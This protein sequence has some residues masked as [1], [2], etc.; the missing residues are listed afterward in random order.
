MEMGKGLVKEVQSG[1]TLIIIKTGAA[2]GVAAEEFVLSL[3]SLEAPRLSRRNGDAPF[4]QLAKE[5][6]RS[7]CAGQIVTYKIE[8]SVPSRSFGTI[9]VGG[10]D[11]SISVVS[12]GFASVVQSNSSS[13]SESID[14]FLIQQERAKNAGRGKWTKDK[15]RIAAG[16]VKVR[17]AGDGSVTSQELEDI[18]KQIE[19]KPVSAI[20]EYIRD[21]SMMR[22]QLVDFNIVVPFGLA[23]VTC[24]SFRGKGVKL[25]DGSYDDSLAKPEPFAALAKQYTERRL[26]SRLVNIR[27]CGGPRK[28]NTF[29]GKVEHPQGDISVALLKN[30]LARVSDWTLRY[31]PNRI[32]LRAAEGYAK[33]NLLRIWKNYTPPETGN[34]PTIQGTVI[35]VPSGDTLV[36]ENTDSGEEH[37]VTIS[38]IRVPYSGSRDGSKAAEPFSFEAHDTLRSLAI[39]KRVTATVDYERRSRDKDGNERMDTTARQFAT[40]LVGK[41]NLAQELVRKGYAKVARHRA[42]EPRSAAYDDLMESELL[43]EKAQ[44]GIHGN[45]QKAKSQPNDVTRDAQKAKHFMAFLTRPG[46]NVHNG[47]VNYCFNASRFKVHIPKENV[48]V[49]VSLIGVATPRTA[50]AARNGQPAQP[51]EAC[52]G[53]VLKFVKRVVMN[54][55]IQLM[56]E[57]SDERGVALADVMVNIDGR[58]RSLNLELL[59]RGYGRVVRWSA[60]KSKNRSSFYDASDIARDSRIGIW[61][62]YVPK[63]RNENGEEAEGTNIGLVGKQQVHVSHI[64]DGSS[65]YLTIDSED[66]KAALAELQAAGPTLVVPEDP[67]KKKAVVAIDFNGEWCRVRVDKLE[68]EGGIQMADISYLD[69]GNKEKVP[70]SDLRELP[71][72]LAKMK[73]TAAKAYLAFLK[74]PNMDRACGLEAGEALHGLTWEKPLVADLLPADDNGIPAILYNAENEESAK[75]DD[76]NEAADDASANADEDADEDAANGDTETDTQDVKSAA[77]PVESI[78]EKLTKNGLA[79]VRRPR[80][81]R[82][83]RSSPRAKKPTGPN[84]Q[85]QKDLI[86][87]EQSAHDAHVGIWQYG[88]PGDS[89][90]AN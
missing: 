76:K 55:S 47:I 88:D 10:E 89:D 31:T 34:L 63:V 74:V 27:C 7:K 21:G 40:V 64:D 29:F 9:Y 75:E 61:E 24:P 70:A 52:A 35:E 80:Q 18:F 73:P 50:R 54:R 84:A 2:K 58:S 48:I 56:I 14:E 4:A 78:N 49:A 72:K 13:V 16:N 33:N 65:F 51:E 46:E 90:D 81:R 68:T 1:D 83:F 87:L 82:G 43:A 59:K 30:G 37:R 71:E 26:L 53:E 19:D 60:E 36:L 20:I 8:Y 62:N 12:N 79:R 77:A 45:L 32:A 15:K 42:D 22:V 17:H 41:G 3:A 25:A 28:V 66:T 67:L 85:L 69:Y 11:V 57:D 39:G 44:D 23:G 86:S 38:S 5:F 6:L